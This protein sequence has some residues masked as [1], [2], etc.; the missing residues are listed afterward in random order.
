MRPHCAADARAGPARWLRAEG[1]AGGW[2]WQ[3]PHLQFKLVNRGLDGLIGLRSGGAGGER[4]LRA[5]SSGRGGSSCLR[6]RALRARSN[7]RTRRSA[8]RPA[9]G[10]LLAY[11]HAEVIDVRAHGLV[12]LLLRQTGLW[13]HFCDLDPPLLGERRLGALAGRVRLFVQ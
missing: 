8:A 2:G 13:R 5:S 9:R 6:R 7:A 10:S 4:G 12:E 11:L 3:A 1:C